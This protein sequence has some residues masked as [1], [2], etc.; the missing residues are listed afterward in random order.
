M[1]AG[2][3]K[4]LLAI[5]AARGDGYTVEMGLA[6]VASAKH[7]T[8]AERAALE[9]A[10]R[11]DATQV[12]AVRELLELATTEKREADALAALREVAVLDQHDRRAWSRLLT[13]LVDGKRWDEARRVGESAIYVDVQNAEMHMAYA[14]ALAEGGDHARAAFELESA[15]LCEAAPPLKAEAHA[16]LA[17]EKAALGDAAGARAHRDEALRLDP[18]NADAR[19]VKVP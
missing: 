17:R 3:E 4:H 18:G 10:H 16:L 11:F 8:G 19:A 9:A 2:Q 6:E 14:R 13:R 1:I 15:T 5:K 7:D 12:D